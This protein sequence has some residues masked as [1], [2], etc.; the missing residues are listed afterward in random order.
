MQAVELRKLAIGVGDVLPLKR[1]SADAVQVTVAMS[2]RAPV[3]KQRKMK[4]LSMKQ[5]PDDT[6]SAC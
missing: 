4:R 5:K 6:S 2:V 1:T 3:A